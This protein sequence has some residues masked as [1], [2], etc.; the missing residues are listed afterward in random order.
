MAAAVL[1]L[2]ACGLGSPPT[3]A[4]TSPNPTPSVATRPTAAPSPTPTELCTPTNRCLALVTLRGSDAVVVRDITDFNHPRTVGSLG[5]IGFPPYPSAPPQFISASELSYVDG[6]R[7]VRTPLSGSPKATVAEAPGMAGFS[8][9]PDGQTAAYLTQI[10]RS[11]SELHLHNAGQDRVVASIPGLPEVFG[12][13]SQAC[14]D[15]WDFVFTYS[16][17][18]RF[19]SWAQDVTDVV[20]VWD[21]DGKDVTP[22]VASLPFMTVWSGTGFYFR[23]SNG[24]ELYRDGVVSSFMTGVPWMFPDA[25]P[26]GQQIVYEQRD[27][28]G[29]AHVFV[30][31]T[32]TTNVRELAAG[33]ADPVFLS[34]RLIWYRG[35]RLCAPGTCLGPSTYTDKTYIYDLQTGTEYESIIT[36]VYDVWPHAA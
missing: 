24:V 15:T 16:P 10:S 29:L 33:R 20:R 23:D 1:L 31:D 3:A 35:E 7:L 12:C 36:G 14:A 17:D 27:A 2:S 19:I 34:S 28:K 13:E 21:A 25:S 4:A 5:T 11:K 26:G 22:A 6:N 9:S 18:G 8:W 30:V 32:H